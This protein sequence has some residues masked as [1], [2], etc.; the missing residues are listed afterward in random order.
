MRLAEPGVRVSMTHGFDL[1]RRMYTR[2][3]RSCKVF[4][5]H[6]TGK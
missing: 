6:F 2:E 5:T 3:G 1:V 4:N